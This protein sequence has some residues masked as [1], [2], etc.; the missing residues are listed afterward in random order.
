[1]RCFKYFFI[2]CLLASCQTETWYRTPSGLDYRLIASG[3]KDSIARMGQTAKI[4][5]IQKVGDSIMETTVDKMPLYFMVMPGMHHYNPLEVFDYGLRK[6]DSVITMQVVDSMLH[7]KFLDSLPR[8]MKKDDQWITTFK[9]LDVFAN[10]SLLQVG[11]GPSADS[12]KLVGVQFEVRTLKGKL[13]NSTTDTSFHQQGR[14]TWSL[15]P[16]NFPLHWKRKW[17]K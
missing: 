3:T 10:D 8:W 16:A 13:L 5:V 7:K 14:K 1:M 6:G 11:H 15:E 17:K 2:V 12:G 9:V 4:Q